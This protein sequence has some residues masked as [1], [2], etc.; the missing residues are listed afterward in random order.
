MK[1][2]KIEKKNKLLKSNICFIYNLFF[3]LFNNLISFQKI[4]EKWNFSTN[5]DEKSR[6]MS[7][8]DKKDRKM[9]YEKLSKYYKISKKS[10]TN[11]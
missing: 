8:Y 4:N 10:L 11:L 2:N 6:D 1:K 9:A 7:N 5:N 3:F